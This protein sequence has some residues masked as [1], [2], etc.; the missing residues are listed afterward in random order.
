MFDVSNRKSFDA[1]DNWLREAAKF[2]ANKFPCVLCGNK[3]DAPKRVV[4][5]EEAKAFAK[6]KGFEYFET[7][8]CTGANI[9][10]TFMT[11]FEQIVSKQSHLQ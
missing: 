5:E 7:S 6:Q 10:D 2:G 8:A 11:L 9:S 1:L 4:S 3:I